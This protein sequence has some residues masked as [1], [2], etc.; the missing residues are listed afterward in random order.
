MIFSE[1]AREKPPKHILNILGSR[2]GRLTVEKY[3]GRNGMKY[4]VEV[5]CDCGERKIVDASN[6]IWGSTVSCGCYGRE[7]SSELMKKLVSKCRTITV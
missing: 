3:I 2:K 6:V 4:Y 5:V 1:I 7:N